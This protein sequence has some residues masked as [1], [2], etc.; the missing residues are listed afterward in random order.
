MN[1]HTTKKLLLKVTRNI[2]AQNQKIVF[3]HGI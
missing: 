1:F 2:W 3:E